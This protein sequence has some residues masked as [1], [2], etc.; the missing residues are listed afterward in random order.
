M[1]NKN[2]SR[3]EYVTRDT[4]LKLLSDEETARV[5][6]AETAP[7]LMEG[8]EYVDLG[9]PE[10]GVRKATASVVT[11]MGEVLPRKAV[12]DKTWRQILALLSAHTAMRAQL[13]N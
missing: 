4:I 7:Q 1:N 12:H 3:S 2:A 6:N 10:R 13:V 11:T 5:C 8:D 9:T